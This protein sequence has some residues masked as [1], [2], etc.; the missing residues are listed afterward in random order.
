MD[1][2]LQHKEAIIS[3]LS[4]VSLF[5][6]FHTLGIY[7]HNDVM[8]AFGTPEKQILIEPVF[9]QFIQASHGKA[10]YGMDVLLSNPDSIATTA[11]PNYANVWLPGWLDAINSGTNSLFLTIG[12]GDLLG[13]RGSIISRPSLLDPDVRLSPHPAP[14]VLRLSYP[15]HPKVLFQREA[16]SHF[17]LNSGLT[18]LRSDCLPLSLVIGGFGLVE[19]LLMWT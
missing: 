18:L 4:W 13:S 8:Q 12:P 17:G 15:S 2:V 5:L 9:A 1:R 6:G 19:R 10:L 14:D 11:W 7:V 16:M 3:H